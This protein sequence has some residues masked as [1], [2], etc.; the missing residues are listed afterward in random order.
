[1][2]GTHAEQVYLTYGDGYKPEPPSRYFSICAV[3]VCSGNLFLSNG[4]CGRWYFGSVATGIRASVPELTTI[5]PT[6]SHRVVFSGG[7]NTLVACRRGCRGRWQGILGLFLVLVPFRYHLW[8]MMVI[9][10]CSWGSFVVAGSRFILLLLPFSLGFTFHLVF[11]S[12]MD[13]S[14]WGSVR[15][16]SSL[17]H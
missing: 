1:M 12:T 9:H 8:F 3:A 17:Y 7:G 11:C 10:C 5:V 14:Q 4:C 2:L 15:I 13:I 6:V 16:L